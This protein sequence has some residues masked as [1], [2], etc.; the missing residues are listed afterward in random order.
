MVD[1]SLVRSGLW[2]LLVKSE[3]HR[4]YLLHTNHCVCSSIIFHG[5][6]HLVFQLL[7]PERNHVGC[8]IGAV[9]GL[10]TFRTLQEDI[11]LDLGILILPSFPELSI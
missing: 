10:N 1:R 2:G 11:R 8:L 4:V 3:S 6:L 7:L 5:L 9:G